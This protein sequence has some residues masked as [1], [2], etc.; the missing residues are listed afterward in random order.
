MFTTSAQSG[1][2]TAA[3][4]AACTA[5]FVFGIC[6]AT[7]LASSGEVPTA[8]SALAASDAANSSEVATGGEGIAATEAPASETS[9]G[10]APATAETTSPS[11]AT[12][13]SES[14]GA[15]TTVAAKTVAASCEGETFTQPFEAFGDN[16]LYTLVAGSQFAGAEEGWT[17]SGGAKLVTSSHPDG[18]TGSVLQLPKGAQAVSPPTCVTLLYPTARVWLAGNRGVVKTQVVYSTAK[19]VAVARTVAKLQAEGSWSPS[20]TFEV[21][22]QLGGNA[23]GPRPVRFVFTARGSAKESS[24]ELYE[25]YIDPRMR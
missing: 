10:E 22:P 24:S 12:G 25:L 20:P 8:S 23:E 7:A 16:N 21:R 11:E 2:R 17:L 9:A 15:I 19:S 6:S 1:A 18:S 13:G 4:V 3:M 5:L 14:V